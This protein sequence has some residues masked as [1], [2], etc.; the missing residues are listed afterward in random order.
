MT[1][2]L[3]NLRAVYII[4]GIFE[5]N[6]YWI[7]ITSKNYIINNLLCLTSKAKSTSLIKPFMEKC[8]LYQIL[9]KEEKN[10]IVAYPKVMSIYWTKKK[11]L[12]NHL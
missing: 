6:C 9:H 11:N 1:D 7:K 5:E 3:H 2:Y 8:H 4:Q 12:Y 10:K